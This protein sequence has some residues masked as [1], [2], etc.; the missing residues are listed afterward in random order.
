MIYKKVKLEFD[1]AKERLSRTLLIK[2]NTNLVILGAIFCSALRTEFEHCFYF[3]KGKTHYSP[4]VFLAEGSMGMIKEVPMKKYKLKDMGMSFK[5]I[6]DTGENWEFNCKVSNKDVEVNGKQ[7]A[8]LIDGKGQGVWEDNKGTLMAYIVGE[9]DPES[10]INDEEKGFHLPWNFNNSKYG[11]FDYYN[12][13]EASELFDSQLIEDINDYLNNSHDYGFELEVKLL[14]ETKKRRA[15]L[16]TSFGQ[17][18]DVEDLVI[19]KTKTDLLSSLKNI[20]KKYA[21]KYMSDHCYDNYKEWKDNVL[22]MFNTVFESSKD[23]VATLHFFSRLIENENTTN[24]VAYGDD[25]ESNIVFLYR[26]EDGLKYYVPDEIKKI[27]LKELNLLTHQFNIN[28]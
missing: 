16:N 3:E 21:D 20:D 6:Y 27:V 25:V 13:K 10:N 5:F 28:L 15:R 11:D 2:E 26:D 14:K 22:F 1:E 8:Y 23:S 18:M 9:I 17:R 7:P 12:K 19:N 24:I 4:D